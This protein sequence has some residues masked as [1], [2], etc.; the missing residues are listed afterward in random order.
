M[1]GPLA[2]S[3]VLHRLLSI[4][5]SSMTSKRPSHSKSSGSGSLP[6]KVKPPEKLTNEIG[7][8][9]VV[10]GS[11]SKTA[12]IATSLQVLHDSGLLN[13]EGDQSLRG[14]KRMLQID[15]EEWCSTI[16]PL[17]KSRARKIDC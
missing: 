2:T 5:E 10:K 14:F 3:H 12:L 16:T 13:L 17:R 4:A 9:L 7:R 8:K 6:A 15:G 1:Q 11:T